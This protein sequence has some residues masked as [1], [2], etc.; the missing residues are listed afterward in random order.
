MERKYWKMLATSFAVF[1]QSIAAEAATVRVSVDSAGNG[2]NGP[3]FNAALSDDGMI[4]TFDSHASNLVPN[5]TNGVPDIFV[6]FLSTG[7]TIRVSVDS[8]GNQGNGVSGDPEISNDGRYVTFE[9]TASNL[10]PGDTDGGLRDIFI[11]DVLTATTRL[12]SGTVTGQDHSGGN[13]AISADGRFVAFNTGAALIPNDTNVQVDI[14]VYDLQTDQLEQ[15]S[16]DSNGGQGDGESVVPA[17]SADGRL[18]AFQSVATNL[19]PNDTNEQRDMFVHDRQTGITERVSVSSTGA[20]GDRPSGSTS[21]ALSGDGR[22]VTFLSF[23]S[24]LAPGD[25]NGTIDIFVRDRSQNTTTRIA[26]DA[27]GVTNFVSPRI[28]QSG[29]FVVY[30]SDANYLVPNDTNNAI[31]LFLR[32]LQTGT[33]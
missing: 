26:A 24:T 3:S 16:V 22:F 19:V 15:V 10:V 13:P 28:S 33:D 21:G 11:Y 31:D 7:Q 8:A 17:L 18:V 23:S 30:E 2:A 32:D 14:Y 29:R 25:T 12:L 5:D 6:H 20:E 27:S 4:V 9:S 1:F